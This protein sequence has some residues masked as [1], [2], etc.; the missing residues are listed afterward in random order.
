MLEESRLQNAGFKPCN[1]KL[2]LPEVLTF[3]ELL[4]K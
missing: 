1:L 4:C 3:F 2:S